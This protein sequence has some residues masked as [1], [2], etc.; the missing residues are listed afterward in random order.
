[1]QK[2]DLYTIEQQSNG[3]WAVI[4][5]PEDAVHCYVPAR[6]GHPIEDAKRRAAMTADIMNATVDMCSGDILDLLDSYEKAHDRR[7]HADWRD[8]VDA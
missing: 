5:K 2:P 7:Y 6:D 1:M 3:V 8:E 4:Y